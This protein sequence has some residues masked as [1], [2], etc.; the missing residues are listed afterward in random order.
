MEI[1]EGNNKFYIN[2][3]QENKLLKLFLCRQENIWPLSNI[4][5]LMKV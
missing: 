5:M 3:A 4:P 2:D 1:H